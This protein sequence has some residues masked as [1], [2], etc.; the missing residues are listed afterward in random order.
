MK[1]LSSPGAVARS[2][3][4]KPAPAQHSA[5]AD[6][7]GLDIGVAT[8]AP[9]AQIPQQHKSSNNILD[10]L[11]GGSSVAL[12]HAS[13]NDLLDLSVPTTTI[14]SMGAA[15]PTGSGSMPFSAGAFSY[16]NEVHIG[17]VPSSAFMSKEVLP[18]LPNANT[19]ATLVSSSAPHRALHRAPAAV[20]GRLRARLR[21]HRAG[22]GPPITCD[23]TATAQGVKKQ[24]KGK[25]A[26][27][28]VPRKVLS[29]TSAG[30]T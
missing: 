12:V 29:P 21:Q 22:P 8:P 9:P 14:T 4:K 16:P 10:I 11:G 17:N 30:S 13:G 20:Q 18:Y 6:L 15:P 7:L 26:L 23:I 25:V 28:K 3:P 2:T 27:E 19:N 1:S 5:S 24:G